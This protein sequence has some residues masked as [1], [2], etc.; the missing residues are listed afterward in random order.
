M[1]ASGHGGFD[2]DAVATLAGI[3]ERFAAEGRWGHAIDTAR[4]VLRQYEELAEADPDRFAE[5]VAAARTRVE[6]MV[7]EATAI[8]APTA[9]EP[10][11]QVRQWVAAMATAT[12]PA[13]DAPR[14]MAAELDGIAA[15]PARRLRKAD[16]S[17]RAAVDLAR[18]LPATTAR[19]LAEKLA[20]HA[21]VL[22]RFE[23][24]DLAHDA[25]LE[26]V[27]LYET[28]DR[29]PRDDGYRAYCLYLL[30]DGWLH[31][32]QLDAA[33]ATAAQ[34]VELFKH[35]RGRL[36]PENMYDLVRLLTIL[37]RCQRE[38]GEIEQGRQSV[39]DA[40]AIADAMRREVPG[41]PGSIPTVPWGLPVVPD[42]SEVRAFYG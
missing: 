28:V 34:A 31:G 9:V 26:A 41:I 5:L 2:P 17:V 3:A 24:P 11:P 8:G 38:R 35:H 4:S 37:A 10:S 18:R 30:A 32:D 1:V 19:D 16:G 13:L 39:V 7:A 15:I 22:R 29:Q 20:R 33:Y 21:V 36:V 6:R 12:D 14:A 40:K 25:A 42:A 27:R 23:R